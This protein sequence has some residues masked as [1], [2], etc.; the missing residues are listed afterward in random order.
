MKIAES[1]I[2]LQSQ[3]SA[4]ERSEQREQLRVWGAKGQKT[5]SGQGN[6]RPLDV[7]TIK[8]NYLAQADQV[9][10]SGEAPKVSRPQRALITPL[11]KDELPLADLNLEILQEMIKRITG[12]I[13]HFRMPQGSGEVAPVEV[14]Q[15]ADQAAQVDEQGF[16]MAYDY[17]ES[18]Y[19]Y[20][21]TS[22]S[23][24]GS[25]R[26]EDGKEIDFTVQLNMSREFLA[27]K[28]L[29]IEVG[30]KLKDPLVVNFGGAAAQIT[31]TDFVFDIDADGTGDQIGFVSPRSGLLALDRDGSGIIE[32]GR[33]LF[34]AMTG[35]G[36]R[37]LAAYDTDRNDWID[38]NDEI[39]NSLRIWMKDADGKDSL[40]SL[41]Q[42]GVGAIYLNHI[43]TPFSLKSADNSMLGQVHESGVYVKED[44][45]VGTIQKI[46]FVA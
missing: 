16:G 18:H 4:V 31:N 1:A 41:G 8:K 9:Q 12:K 39:Y 30:E 13:F 24:Q 27:E 38:E 36:F 45:S 37:E 35:D 43:N 44:G 20:E 14:E 15:A 26:T 5:L 34:G 19:E 10:L 32:D 11:T 40:F 28:H 22:F 29:S 7:E 46:D 25:I 21:A 42:K 17:Y 23:G 2:T 3:H 6:D 33:E